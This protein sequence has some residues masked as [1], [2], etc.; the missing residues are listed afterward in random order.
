VLR[1]PIIRGEVRQAVLAELIDLATRHAAQRQD[2][3][4]TASRP[5]SMSWLSGHCQTRPPLEI[6]R[7]LRLEMVQ[8]ER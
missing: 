7:V 5:V 8:G 4:Q 2:L 1:C 3:Q 6:A